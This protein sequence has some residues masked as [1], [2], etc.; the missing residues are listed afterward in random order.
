MS[1]FDI[2]RHKVTVRHRDKEVTYYARELGYFEFQELED[3]LA[4]M[5]TK[6]D[7]EKNRRGL[8]MMKRVTLASIEDEGGNAVLTEEG[9]KRLPWTVAKPLSDA[10]MKAQGI[11]MEKIREQAKREQEEG[12]EPTE[13]TPEGNG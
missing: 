3:G 5:P 12:R 2:E 9:L 7:A 10:A 13:E 8:E 1:E 6:T 11:D 4:D